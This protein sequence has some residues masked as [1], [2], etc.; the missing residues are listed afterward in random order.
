VCG[1]MGLQCFAFGPSSQNAISGPPG[2]RGFWSRRYIHI[3][4]LVEICI[5]FRFLVATLSGRFPLHNCLIISTTSSNTHIHTHTST[6]KTV[7]LASLLASACAFAP[8]QQKAA[9][10]TALNLDVSKAIGVQAP[11]GYF[12]PLNMM[13]DAKT[14]D[15]EHFNRL[16]YVELKHGRIAMLGVV[17]FL[18]TY[19]G[20]R[21]PGAQDMPSGWA[22]LSAIPG[23]VWAQMLFTIAM[24]EMANRDST[25]KGEFAGDFRNGA[26]DFGWDKL[27]D[28]TKTRKRAI[29][30][31]QGRAAQ[32]GLLGLMVHDAMGNVADILPLG[33]H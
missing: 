4:N 28:A 12:D 22:A 19:A 20:V 25:G 16:R 6:M 10:T 2:L 13:G 8:A 17:G 26:L 15:E 33:P 23:M 27:D 3:H 31:N 7:I 30:L 24:M 5:P 29:E 18:T 11:L 1:S 21:F 32:M 9:S 14:V